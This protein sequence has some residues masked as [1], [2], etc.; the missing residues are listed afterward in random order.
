MTRVS[1]GVNFLTKRSRITITAPAP[2]G[3]LGSYLFNYPRTSTLFRSPL[4]RKEIDVKTTKV[5]VNAD[6]YTEAYEN[7]QYVWPSAAPSASTQQAP[8]R[9]STAPVLRG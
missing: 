8:S 3:A 2:L 1:H 4:I 7:L 9:L 5:Y 6:G